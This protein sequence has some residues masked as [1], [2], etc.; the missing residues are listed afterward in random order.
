MRSKRRIGSFQNEVF[1]GKGKAAGCW[2][3][4]DLFNF[5]EI[6][7]TQR[8]FDNLLQ[9]S[10]TSAELGLRTYISILRQQLSHHPT[11]DCQLPTVDCV[12]RTEDRRLKTTSKALLFLQ[13]RF[14]FF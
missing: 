7:F 12:L 3:L 4:A 1:N 13:M 5:K 6:A 9:T 14:R 8:F 2:H 10:I 11:A